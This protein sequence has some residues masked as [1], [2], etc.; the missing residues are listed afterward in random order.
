MGSR[1]RPPN[2]TVDHSHPSPSLSEAL[3]LDMRKL[4]SQATTADECRLLV[5]TFITRAGIVLDPAFSPVVDNTPPPDAESLERTLVNYFL[6]ADPDV[7]Q[8]PQ[9][10]PCQA[11]VERHSTPSTP[12]QAQE[13]DES[14]ATMDSAHAMHTHHI[15]SDA[16]AVVS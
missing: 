11:E 6:G 3:A 1:A 9:T 15:V 13:S 14:A 8:L 10:Q 2:G 12:I 7:L 4:L 5:D 16:V